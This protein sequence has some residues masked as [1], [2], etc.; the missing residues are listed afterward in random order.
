VGV[1][2]VVV[3]CRAERGGGRQPIGREVDG[4]VV[5]YKLLHFHQKVF[6]LTAPPVSSMKLFVQCGHK[7][8]HFG[9]VLHS[10][11][12]KFGFVQA[13]LAVGN[14]MTQVFEQIVH[15]ETALSFCVV[16]FL[17]FFL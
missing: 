15:L 6:Q 1:L 11:A 7:Q 2:V 3:G 9:D 12:E 4:A 16:V 14:E 8:V 5:L 17:S 13:L 10:L